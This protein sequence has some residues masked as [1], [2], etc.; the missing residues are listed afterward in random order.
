MPKTQGWYEFEDG[1]IM[2][3]YGMS[4]KEKKIETRKH[5]KIV[6]FTPGC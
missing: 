3:V 5:G 2:W 6:R 4:A 1:H